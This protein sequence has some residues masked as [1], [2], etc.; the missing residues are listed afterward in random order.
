ELGG[1]HLRVA[2]AGPSARATE[3][4]PMPTEASGRRSAGVAIDGE[5]EEALATRNLAA[6]AE[7]RSARSILATRGVERTVGRA[8]QDAHVPA[9]CLA[10]LAPEVGSVA[11][12][13]AVL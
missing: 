7:D 11:L 12:L 9:E 3:G 6:V 8:R 10:G 1:S 4:T 2:G 13:G 5:A